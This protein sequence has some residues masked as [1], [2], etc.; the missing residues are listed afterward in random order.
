ML[1]TSAPGGV[2]SLVLL[3]PVESTGPYGYWL[4]IAPS[5]ASAD[6]VQA[7]AEWLRGEGAKAAGE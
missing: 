3:S 4:D 1:T 5:F 2:D 7:F 6:R